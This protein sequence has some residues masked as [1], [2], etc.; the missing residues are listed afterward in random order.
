MVIHISLPICRVYLKKV[1]RSAEDRAV[2]QTLT[3]VLTDPNIMVRFQ[4]RP[5][6]FSF[7]FF[8]LVFLNFSF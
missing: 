8:L 4:T 3:F 6:L 1:Q 2:R 5:D 7:F